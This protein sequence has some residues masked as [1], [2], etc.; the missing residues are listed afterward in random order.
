MSSL[1]VCLCLCVAGVIYLG[2]DQFCVTIDRTQ[3]D[4]DFVLRRRR[5]DRED[6]GSGQRVAQL[7]GAQV[8]APYCYVR[9]RGL[10]FQ[11]DNADVYISVVAIMAMIALMSVC[12]C[13]CDAPD[14]KLRHFNY[15]ALTRIS[16]V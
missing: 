14:H 10:S 7:D 11:C 4:E 1:G 15:I 13:V 16:Y 6:I 8:C 12:V 3:T 2:V 9:E 5:S